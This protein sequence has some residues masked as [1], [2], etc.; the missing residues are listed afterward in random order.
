MKIKFNLDHDLLLKKKLN[1]YK[2]EIA[3]RSVFHED[4]RY[5]PQA[6]WNVCLYKLWMLEYDRISV[7]KEIGVNN[8]NA[9]KECNVCGI[10]W[11]KSLSF[12]RMSVMSVMI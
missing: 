10:F 11:K 4:K 8:K 2:M 12:S 7:S 9:S 1:F 6:F 5:Y 3:V